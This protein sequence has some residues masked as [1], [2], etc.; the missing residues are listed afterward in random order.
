MNGLGKAGVTGSS[1]DKL[2]GAFWHEFSCHFWLFQLAN[3]MAKVAQLPCTKIAPPWEKLGQY[4]SRT[5]P[6]SN[7]C[8][9][10][11]R[12]QPTNNIMQY[13]MEIVLYGAILYVVMN[14]IRCLGLVSKAIYISQ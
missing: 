6:F 5:K 14:W 1:S 12:Q 2:I 3:V 11:E 13:C 9:L 7:Y 8:K 10:V 4:I